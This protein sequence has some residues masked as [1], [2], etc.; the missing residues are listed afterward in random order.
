MAAAAVAAIAVTLPGWA[1]AETP[2]ALSTKPKSAHSAYLAG[3]MLVATPKM[4]DP[5]F[6]KTVIFMVSHDASGA[7]GLVVNRTLGTASLAE[8]L[9]GLGMEAQGVTGDIRIH[10]GGPVDPRAG[11]ILHTTTGQ[12]ADAR[13]PSIIV[14]G[15]ITFTTQLS[16]LKDIAVGKGPEKSMVIF[17]YAGWGP[18]Q[19]EG[20]INR[21]DWTTAPADP[22]LI[23]DETLE[24][25]WEKARARSGRAL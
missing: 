6:A 8:L 14:N 11:F 5:R 22:D 10:Y 23:F 4:A 16:V 12:G 15:D 18:R 13:P 24:S 1:A 3:Q 7:L 17:G 20:E 2:S 9:K 21:D 19:L 25:K